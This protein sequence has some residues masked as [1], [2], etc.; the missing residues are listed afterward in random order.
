ML[1][2]QEYLKRFTLKKLSQEF[3]I[4][5]KIC[6]DLGVVCL[7][8]QMFS[9]I[10]LPIVQE[11]RCLI[12]ELD[13]WDVV[14]KSFN[15]FYDYDDI[16]AQKTLSNFNWDNAR[17]MVKYDGALI[18]MY[19]YKGQWNIGMR[20]SADGSLLTTAIHG[21]PSKY[22]FAELTK[23][24]IEEM[25]YSFDEF[26]S[27]LNPNIFYSFELCA[28][29]TRYGV[30]YN[31]RCLYLIGAVDKQTLKDIDIYSLDYPITKAKYVIVNSKEEVLRMMENV[32]GIQLEGYVVIDSNMNRIKFRNPNYLDVMLP[33]S[34][35]DE[36]QALF[37][38]IDTI[39]SATCLSGG[40]WTVTVTATGES[41]ISTPPGE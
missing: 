10:E 41:G 2:V 26:T 8:Y 16:N 17:A 5:T 22:T 23:L 20:K 3:F 32:P 38:I 29:E 11:C 31:D 15:A 25:G 24:T 30:V 9:P 27:K 4:D 34:A 35:D 7:D 33:A 12:L 6:Y 13:T 14:C 18:V 40:T 1:R 37:E 19:Y 39:S 21:V 28:P 36:L